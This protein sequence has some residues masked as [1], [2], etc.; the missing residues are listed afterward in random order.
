[1]P[2]SWAA[3]AA[4][5][6]SARCSVACRR[7]SPPRPGA[8][9]PSRDRTKAS[10]RILIA[11]I[12]PILVYCRGGTAAT[13]GRVYPSRVAAGEGLWLAAHANNAGCASRNQKRPAG[14]IIWQ[15][16]SCLMMDLTPSVS[17]T[18]PEG[19]VGE[20]HRRPE[21]SG[22]SHLLNAGR[23]LTNSIGTWRCRVLSGWGQSPV[24]D[25]LALLQPRSRRR[26][27]SAGRERSW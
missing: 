19:T 3:G 17:V 16:S 6:S 25:W 13:K 10:P 14:S 12:Q 8:W 27:S 22:H 11:T 7:G 18:C 9:W 21:E 2:L 20:C 5:G 24:W 4:A 26:P 23:C 1:M 15:A